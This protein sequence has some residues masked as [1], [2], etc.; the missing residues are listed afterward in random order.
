[1]PLPPPPACSVAPPHARCPLRGC[2]RLEPPAGVPGP[3]P[4]TWGGCGER[5]QL[6]G[7]APPPPTRM[8]VLAT[9]YTF[10]RTT[11]VGLGGGDRDVSLFCR[12][13]S[14]LS[15]ASCRC[16]TE[17]CRF[18]DS[19]ESLPQAQGCKLRAAP[20]PLY[21]SR[22]SVPASREPHGALYIM[23]CVPLPRAEC[24]PGPF[25][26]FHVFRTREPR[27][28]RGPS[29]YSMCSVPASREPLPSIF[30]CISALLP[31]LLAPDLLRICSPLPSAFAPPACPGPTL[32][33]PARD[34]AHA[35]PA[36]PSWGA[37]G[38]PSS[39]PL[40]RAALVNV[41]FSISFFL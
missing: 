40:S 12:C 36:R 15:S 34:R 32:G 28:V 10:V 29:Y 25:I 16:H 18:D 8:L 7:C 27:A 4:P 41:A 22:F 5:C 14:N 39:H 35:V 17:I 24:R 11:R 6:A 3:H 20:G 23:L 1:M 33:H 38:H 26:L 30:F 21:Y 13:P 19:A 37:G 9:P 2:C 31:A